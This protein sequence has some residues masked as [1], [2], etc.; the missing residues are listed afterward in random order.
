ME[1]EFPGLICHVMALSQGLPGVSA[2]LVQWETRIWIQT[3]SHT[4]AWFCEANG[5]LVT[6]LCTFISCQALA[7]TCVQKSWWGSDIFLLLNTAL[8]ITLQPS[9]SHSFMTDISELIVM[10]TVVHADA[11]GRSYLKF[12]YSFVLICYFCTFFH[13]FFIGHDYIWHKHTNNCWKENMQGLD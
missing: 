1:K 8:R 13:L 7:V 6:F 2:G 3:K 10:A 4:Q 12:S 11:A 9:S 5:V